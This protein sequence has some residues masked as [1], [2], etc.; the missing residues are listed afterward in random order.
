MLLGSIGS[1][2]SF[3]VVWS[4]KG[5]PKITKAH[6]AIQTLIYPLV[7]TEQKQILFVLEYKGIMLL[8]SIGSISS[9]AVVWSVKG[10]PKIT[11]AHPAIQTLIYPLVKTEQNQILFVLE[12]KGIMLLGSIGSMSSFAVVWSV[13]GRPKITKAHP[14]IQTLIYPLVKT[15]QKQILFVLEY[16][17]IM[18]LGSIGSISSFAVVWSVKGRPKITKA[19]PAIQ[20]LIYPLV[21]TEQN[22]ILFVLEYKGIMLL[23]SIGSMSSFA[24]VWSVKG[25]PKITKAHPA[26]QTLIYPLVKTEQKQILFVLEYKG[27]M[28]LGSIGSMSSFAVVWSVKG[29]PKITKAHP[30]IQTL[31]YPFVE[32]EQIHKLLFWSTR[33]VN[34]W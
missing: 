11:K 13:K 5:R 19:H 22:Q 17:G 34:Y 26:I 28:L 10:R 15:E 32:T 3:A 20:T 30:A 16:K 23:G 18:L 21:K 4:V 33:E 7:K 2:S 8:G 25:R 31:I 14:A 24:V 27:I 29:R 12:Y 9:F 1:I 6:P